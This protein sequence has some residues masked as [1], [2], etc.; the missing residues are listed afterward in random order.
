M[1]SVI[2]ELKTNA[3]RDYILFSGLMHW[4]EKDILGGKSK[5]FK[6]KRTATVQY[7]NAPP[8]ADD[9]DATKSIFRSRRKSLARKFLDENNLL[10]RD[11]IKLEKLAPYTYRFSKI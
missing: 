2:I 10:P 4:F 1:N 7:G 11:L 6:A 9:I 8:V 5:K 3:A